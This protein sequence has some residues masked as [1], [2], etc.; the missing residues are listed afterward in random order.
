MRIRKHQ[1]P[2]QVEHVPGLEYREHTVAGITL[3]QRP[4]VRA[5]LFA[6]LQHPV[7]IHCRY[8]SAIG[9]KLRSPNHNSSV[10]LYIPVV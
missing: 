10:R 9:S 4:S 3:C 6:C 5:R 1:E 7:C 8:A 2:Q